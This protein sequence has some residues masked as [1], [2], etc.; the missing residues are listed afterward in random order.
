MQ[1]SKG[2]IRDLLSYFK[3]RPGILNRTQSA[4]ETGSLTG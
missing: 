1:D 3:L 4:A 2:P